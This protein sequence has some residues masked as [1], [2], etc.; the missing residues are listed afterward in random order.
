[1]CILTLIH[2]QL[3]VYSVLGR[4]AG[5]NNLDEEAMDCELDES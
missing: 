2:L 5:G 4:T 1:M 3:D